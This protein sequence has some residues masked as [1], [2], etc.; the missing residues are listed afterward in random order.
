MP[1]SL[2]VHS[3]IDGEVDWAADG[4]VGIDT[5]TKMEYGKVYRRLDTAYC[6]SCGIDTVQRSDLTCVLRRNSG[7]LG[8][9]WTM[10]PDHFAKWS[11]REELTQAQQQANHRKLVATV[12]PSCF[13]R[14]SVSGACLCS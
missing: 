5:R 4:A 14:R 6:S 3:G 1:G 9:G 13:T 7:P 12:C 2:E 8:H 11:G 10:C